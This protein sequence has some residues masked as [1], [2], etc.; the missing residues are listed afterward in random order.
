MDSEGDKQHRNEQAAQ[1]Y[2]R[3]HAPDCTAEEREAFAQWLTADAQNERAY[4]A[5]ERILRG[6]DVLGASDSRYTEMADRALTDSS[7]STDGDRA[8]PTSTPKASTTD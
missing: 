6:M 8:N 7:P 5:L 3:L 2:A 1:W 4:R